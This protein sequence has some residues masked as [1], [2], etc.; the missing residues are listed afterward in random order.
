MKF[1]EGKRTYIVA[2]I[3][4]VLAGL[5]AF[6]ISVPQSVYTLLGALGLYTVRAAIGSK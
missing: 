4:A 3:A 1:L 5:E 2:I 6:G